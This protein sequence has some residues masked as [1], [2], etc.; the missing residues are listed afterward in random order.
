MD[1]MS[2]V[3]DC[4]VYQFPST[5]VTDCCKSGGFTQM[6]S[7]TALGA[8]S[9]TSLSWQ[10][11][12]SSEGP[13]EMSH[14]SPFLASGGCRP[15]AVPLAHG[16]VTSVSASIFVWLSSLCVCLCLGVQ[17]FIFFKGH[18]YLPLGPILMY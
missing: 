18:R 8:R 2:R 12:A 9:L 13:E 10:G 11:Q 3:G 14:P 17:L 5:A 7:L 15:S 6:Y 1:R 16:C 4:Q